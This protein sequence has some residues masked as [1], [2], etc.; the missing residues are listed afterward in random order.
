MLILCESAKKV[1]NI[2]ING[3]NFMKCLVFSDSHG[4]PFYMKRAI[5]KNPDAEVVFFLGDGISDAESV[6]IDDRC[7]MW[8]AV[9]GNCDFS[10]FFCNRQLNK[11]E[12]ITLLGKKIMLTHGDLYGV[13]G[14]ME[15]IALAAR[16]RGADIVLF[17]HT[18]LPYESYGDGLYFFNPGSISQP[19]FSFGILTLT[20]CGVLFSHGSF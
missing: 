4:N 2:K 12:E 11:T 15:N 5:A 20:E 9:R 17:G 16:S 19:H 14:G 7:R 10:N 6:A 18:H 8:I 3:V 1:T 13:K